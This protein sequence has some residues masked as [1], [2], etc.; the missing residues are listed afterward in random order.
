MRVSTHTL[1]ENIIRQ[2]QQL[3]SQQTKL[4]MQVATGQRIFQPEDDP[5]S[6]G[7][8]LA[9][10]SE[11]REIG[12]Y[13]RNIDRALE[14]SQLSFAGLRG[15]KSSSDRATEIGVLGAGPLSDDAARAYAAEVNQ[16]IEQALQVANTKLRNDYVFAG[17]AVDTPPFTATRNPSGEVTG[18]TYVGN[19]DQAPI[20]L[21]ESSSIAPGTTGATNA[22]L[23]TFLNQLVALRD[24]LNANDSAAVTTA[25][26]GLIASEDGL[27]S[28]LAE[29]GG[30]QMRIEA[31][32][33]QLLSRSENL[34]RLA[35]AEADLDLPTTIVR[36]NQSQTAYQAALQSAANIM[37]L[38]L[39]DYI[40]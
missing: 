29:H 16:L 21:S 12:Q 19:A 4:Q 6:V 15:L 39:L 27:V 14:I 32:R 33:T 2:I 24:A 30:V 26:A 25:Q 9:L 28:S 22:G 10:E 1:S 31:S 18:V 38:S 17:T 20:Q 35:S 13:V 7:R 8:V 40:R 23:G 11:Q 3:G 36:L 37:R 34:E 5:T